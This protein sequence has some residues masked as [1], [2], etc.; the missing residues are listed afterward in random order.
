MRRSTTQLIKSNANISKCCALCVHVCSM[1]HATACALHCK[2]TH[3]HSH[4]SSRWCVRALV[5]AVLCRCAFAIHVIFVILSLSHIYKQRVQRDSLSLML[6][7][8]VN[9]VI[10][11]Q[12]NTVIALP[13]PHYRCIYLRLLV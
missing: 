4:Q 12:Q 13:L 5:C 2:H 6:L 11:P 7:M 1:R 10:I 8:R 3:A 9:K